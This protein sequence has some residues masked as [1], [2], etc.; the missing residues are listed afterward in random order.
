MPIDLALQT[1]VDIF[2]RFLHVVVSALGC[3]I[4][5]LWPYQSLN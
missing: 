3:A 2:L 5:P 4:K 1:L